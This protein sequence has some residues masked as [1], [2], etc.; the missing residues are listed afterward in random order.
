MK[1]IKLVFNIALISI[2]VLCCNQTETNKIKVPF[3]LKIVFPNNVDLQFLSIEYDNGLEH[4]FMYVQD[5]THSVNII[6]TLHRASFVPIELT[7]NNTVNPYSIKRNPKLEKL[8]EP[9]AK[10]IS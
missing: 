7:Y 8:K 4:K 2:L 5:S 3:K 6:D 10:A 1:K 9:F